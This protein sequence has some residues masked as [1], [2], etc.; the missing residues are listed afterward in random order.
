[1]FSRVE[2]VDRVELCGYCAAFKFVGTE[3]NYKPNGIVSY[4]EVV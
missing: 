3:V 2:R 4:L 1:M